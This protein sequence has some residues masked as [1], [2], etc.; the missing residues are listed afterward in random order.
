MAPLHREPQ[1]QRHESVKSPF[2]QLDKA[3]ESSIR[4]TRGNMAHPQVSRETETD[5]Q[6][7]EDVDKWEPNKPPVLGWQRAEDAERNR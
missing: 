1:L 4:V 6:A 5:G 3:Q 2:I 7:R